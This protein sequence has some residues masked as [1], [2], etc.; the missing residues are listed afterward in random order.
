MQTYAHANMYV[1]VHIC[2]Y[3]SLSTSSSHSCMGGTTWHLIGK[4]LSCVGGGGAAMFFGIP[5][6]RVRFVDL[7]HP[8]LFTRLSPSSLFLLFPSIFHSIV[9][10]VEVNFTGI[11]P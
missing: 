5:Y 9:V 6:K 10:A 4:S 1:F 3:I 7:F 11:C 2:K 8:H